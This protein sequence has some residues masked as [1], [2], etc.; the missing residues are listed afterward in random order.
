MVFV[1]IYSCEDFEIGDLNSRNRILSRLYS[2]EGKLMNIKVRW[3]EFVVLDLKD[4]I[5]LCHPIILSFLLPQNID[6]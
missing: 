5:V 2:N 4:Y 3:M 6:I 1:F